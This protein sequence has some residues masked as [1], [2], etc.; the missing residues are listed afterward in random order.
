MRLAIIPTP[1]FSPLLPLKPPSHECLNVEN[2]KA[3]RH[4][5]NSA[6]GENPILLEEHTST[7]TYLNISYLLKLLPETPDVAADILPT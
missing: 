6:G 5:F 4:E 3:C 7:A 1:F 2:V